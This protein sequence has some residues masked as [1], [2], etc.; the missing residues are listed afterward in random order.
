M[1][2]LIE[3]GHIDKAITVVKFGTIENSNK[4]VCIDP[5]K[6]NKFTEAVERA[7]VLLNSNLYRSFDDY[8][9]RDLSDLLIKSNYF[10]KAVEVSKLI[11][12]QDFRK[13]V[14]DDCYIEF[15]KNLWEKESFKESFE[16]A[17]LI[18]HGFNKEKINTYYSKHSE[19]FMRKGEGNL[20]DFLFFNC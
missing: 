8:I 6:P 10:E 20:S 9:L 18:S 5:V 14:L 7:E 1:R 4:L 3:R 15:A 11:E 2:I 19:N 17:S 12:K 13:I 16:I